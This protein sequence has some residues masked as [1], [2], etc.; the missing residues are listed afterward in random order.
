MKS[1]QWPLTEVVIGGRVRGQVTAG[2]G[3]DECGKIT[4]EMDAGA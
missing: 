4:L 3:A 2:V 1:E